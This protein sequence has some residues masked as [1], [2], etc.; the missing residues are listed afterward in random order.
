MSNI[1]HASSRGRLSAKYFVV[2]VVLV[3]ANLRAPVTSIG[4]VLPTIQTALGL[5]DVGA[6]LLN[7]LPLLIFALLSLVAPRVGRRFGLERTLGAALAAIAVGTLIR[8]LTFTGSLWIGTVVL[9][10]GIAFGNVLLPGLVKRDAQSNA[11]SLIGMYAA[12]MAAVAGLAAGLAVPVAELPSSD[13]RWGIGIWAIFAVVA[14]LVWIP[15]MKGNEHHLSKTAPTAFVARSPW[16]HAIGWHVSLFFAC[17]SL[18]FYSLV[19][20]FATYAQSEG[21]TT[22]EAG[23]YLLVYQVVSVVTNLACAPMIRKF[24]D[25]TLLG[26]LCGLFL[27]VATT[28]LYIAPSAALLWIV[29]AGLGAGLSM[30]TSLSLFG[31]RTRDHHSAVVLSG[32]GQFVGYI[33]AAAGPL[34]FGVLHMIGQSWTAPFLLLIVVSIFVSVFAIM[35]GRDRFIE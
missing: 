7:S 15:L 28:G 21:M 18:V 23:F 14:F 34:L 9:S 2:A 33:G 13:W 29:S 32:M 19:D 27:V 12:A 10:V 31:L 3:G 8:S 11:A 16:R 5:D 1:Q 24:K 17:H 20:W 4:P 25:Q 6:G 26:F 22:K 35:A 30:T